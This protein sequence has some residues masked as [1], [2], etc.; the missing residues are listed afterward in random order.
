MVTVRKADHSSCVVLV[1]L[2]NFDQETIIDPV[3]ALLMVWS[4][5]KEIDNSNIVLS[6]E[7]LVKLLGCIRASATFKTDVLRRSRNGEG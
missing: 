6:N 7:K 1:A 3:E 2:R 5:S 4:A